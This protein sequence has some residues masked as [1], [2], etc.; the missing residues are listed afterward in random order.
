MC[1][2]FLLEIDFFI[3]FEDRIDFFDK[4]EGLVGLFAFGY[5]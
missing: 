4:L 1:T 2:A 5:P 3:E